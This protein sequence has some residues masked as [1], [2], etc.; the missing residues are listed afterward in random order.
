MNKNK[1]IT[2][3]KIYKNYFEKVKKYKEP[4][5]EKSVQYISRKKV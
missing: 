1:L 3:Q 4:E 5:V 2:E